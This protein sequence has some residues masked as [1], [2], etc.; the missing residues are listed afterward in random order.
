MCG[1]VG[2]VSGKKLSLDDNLSIIRHRGPDANGKYY[3]QSNDMYIG[4]GHVRLS[5]IDLDSHSNQPFE[6]LD[7]YIIVYNGEI[8]NYV[9]IKKDLVKNNYKFSTSSD[10]E[11]LI[12]A[13]DYY[14]E[15]I[16][17]Y[18]DGMFAFCI[19][20]K[21]EN[22]L[23]CARDH[24]GIK[25]LYYYFNQKSNEFYFS[26]ELKGL[27]E[28]KEVP[29]KISQNAICEFLINGWLYEPDT[30]FEDIFKVMPGSY[31]E[32]HLNTFEI[33]N[34][35]YFDVSEEKNNLGNLE[36][37][38]IESLIEHSIDIQC[39]SDVPLGV[40]FSGGVDSTL[41]A[42]KIDNPACLTAKYNEDDI[43]DSGMGNDYLYSIE[44]A[45][46]LDLDLTP[47]QLEQ[48]EYSI[49]TIKNIVKYTEEPIADFTYQITERISFQAREQGYK[50]MLSGMGA[51]EIFGGYPRYKYV[52]YKKF[53]SL[54]SFFSQPFNKIIKKFKF[55]AKK[56]DR[57]HSFISEKDF[58]FAYSSLIVGFSR[59]EVTNLIKDKNSLKI[60]HDKISTYLNRVKD[61]SDYK[62]AFYLD[63]YGFLSHNFIQTD[64]ASMHSSVEVRV[65]LINK[66]LLVKNFYEDDNVLL[67]FWTMKKQLKNLL[68]EI[69]PDRM[70]DRKKTGFTPP[71]D[72]LIK[73]L[74]KEKIINIV[75]NGNLKKY[76]NIR[77]VYDLMDEHFSGK[78]NNTYGLWLILYLNYW[79]E[80][81]E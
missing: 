37:Q 19:Y 2:Y 38:K 48:E 73:N 31:M 46:E 52:K 65:P 27:F 81:N 7:R 76:I 75:K 10:T 41:I 12:A 69:L 35:I 16:F 63:L 47:I 11:V 42:S 62:K 21:V 66:Y 56:V 32:Y 1:I 33:K 15:N 80:E 23:I 57:F 17:D 30:G 29:K 49:K 68:R 22:K 77:Y 34:K 53:Y 3:F 44:I 18:L 9:E 5:I 26:S 50:V 20:D 40:F 72:R 60:Y 43:K 58:G 61:H 70:I 79:I 59:K 13:Y 25:P 78:N 28:F 54:I 64:K 14:K 4:L 8:Y 36:G 74:G 39:R 71:M 6:Y 45:H 51:D 55:L 67:D 24:V